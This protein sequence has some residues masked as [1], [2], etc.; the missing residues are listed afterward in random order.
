[1]NKV[2]NPNFGCI[3]AGL[4]Y[5]NM[6]G[7]VLE[8]GSRSGKTYAIVDFIIQLCANNKDKGLVINIIKETYA[9]FKTT[10]YDDF[11]KR[12]TTFQIDNP[13]AITR[14][15]PT[16]YLFG[17]KIAFL[18]ADQSAKFH[19]AGCDYFWINE[20][21]DV[22]QAIFDQLEMR[23]RKAWILDYNPKCSE[24][25]IFNKL[26]NRSDVKFFHSTML[27]NP[28]VS[29]WEK[30]KILSYE[31][32]PDNIKSG[33]A[34]EV[35]WKV[36]G[37]GLR[38]SPQGLI[39]PN[40]TWIT[41]F[42][43]CDRITYG[44]DFGFSCS[45]M[46]VVKAGLSGD[47]LYLQK[48]L[49]T[50]VDNPDDMAKVLKQILPSGKHVWGDAAHPITINDLNKRG[51]RCLAARKVQG[52][53]ES[54]ISLLKTYKIH[55]VRDAD[56]RREQENYHWREINGIALNEPIHEFCHLW[57]SVRYCCMM[58]FNRRASFTI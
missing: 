56:F 7:I 40:V 11:N 47:N 30:Q 15:I 55:I 13:F 31:P 18:G 57:D 5:G 44:V 50:P 20:A 19:G 51:V 35:N 12:L 41:E 36:Y 53:I 27:D 28:Y 38:A 58:D 24:H 48:M 8:G 45:P 1:M 17:N 14:D 25:W 33:T 46:A 3:A 10:L 32:T 21:I 6:R 2:I 9:G 26:E 16:F 49:Y 4:W 29:K 42:P 43:V 22:Q 37:L 34:D 52:S 23:C 39:F 54:G